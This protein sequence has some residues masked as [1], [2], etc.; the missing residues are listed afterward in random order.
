[1]YTNPSDYF[2]GLMRDEQHCQHLLELW[3]KADCSGAGSKDIAAA[4]PPV[5]FFASSRVRLLVHSGSLLC[6]DVPIQQ[7]SVLRRKLSEV[8][9]G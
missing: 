9:T 3:Q 1:M 5:P 8:L 4:P 6:C 2:M 7:V